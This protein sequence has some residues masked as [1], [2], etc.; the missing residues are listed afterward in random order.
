MRNVISNK[1][2]YLRNGTS[3]KKEKDKT[4]ETSEKSNSFVYVIGKAKVQ[5]SFCF[6]QTWKMFCNLCWIVNIITDIS[7]R[8][9]FAFC[10]WLV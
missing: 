1:I 9:Y 2:K 5:T 7:I 4:L 8:Y 10:F 6:F 3:F